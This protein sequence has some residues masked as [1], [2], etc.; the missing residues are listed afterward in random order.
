[1][2]LHW[3]LGACAATLTLG[4]GAY[5]ADLPTT[6]TPPA[7][8]LAAS[9]FDSVYAYMSASAQ[10]CPLTWKGI[11]LYGAIDVGAGYATHGVNLNPS[12]NN[13]VQEVIAKFS[14]G[15]RFQLVPNGLSQSNVG[16]RG[17]E[18]FTPGWSLVFDANAGF[19]PYTL[20][21][22]SGA[23]SLVDNNN[24][25]IGNQ[26]ANQDSSRAG[27]WDN[28]RGYVGLSNPTFGTLTIGRETSLSNDL[29]TN[30]DPMGGSYAFSVIG[31]SS[32]YVSGVGDTEVSRYNTALKYQVGY[33]NF[34]AAAAW[35]FGGYEQ[36]NGSNGA[37]QFDLG[38]DYGGF[39]FD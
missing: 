14:Q 26:N 15:P 11:T 3:I 32:T 5:A 7:P 36:G 25:T 12:W 18:E 6:K 27:Q 31:T 16:I 4:A 22:A 35:Q 38:A 39:S 10:D 13:G 30:Y 1:M 28:T 9:C 20:Q 24:K 23:Q 2:K 29:V 19:D 33:Q 21:L 17:S 8:I 34:R 37:Y